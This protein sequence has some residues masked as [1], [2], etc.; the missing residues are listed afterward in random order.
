[1]NFALIGL[2]A[3]LMVLFWSA[4][5][6]GGIKLLFS[7]GLKRRLDPFILLSLILGLAAVAR[8]V[9]CWIYGQPMPASL[10]MLFVSIL[11][12]GSSRRRYLKNQL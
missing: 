5:V 8:I 7:K 3:V 12:V 10:I 2:A 4:L 9:Q 1:M 6:I 11:L